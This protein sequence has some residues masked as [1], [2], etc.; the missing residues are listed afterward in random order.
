MLS[1]IRSEKH[2]QFLKAQNAKREGRAEF[3]RSYWLT[4]ETISYAELQR[5]FEI[6]RAME[7]L[8]TK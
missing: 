2:W 6:R 4:D 5:E 8:F 3:A 1:E 7:K